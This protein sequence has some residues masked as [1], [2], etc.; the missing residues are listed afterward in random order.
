MRFLLTVI[1][2]ILIWVIEL[3]W[4]VIWVVKELA[5]KSWRIAHKLMYE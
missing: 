5:I 1:L 3:V 4:S 2:A